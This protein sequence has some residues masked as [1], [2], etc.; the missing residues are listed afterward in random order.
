MER[1][2][3]GITGFVLCGYLLGLCF[4]GWCLNDLVWVCVGLL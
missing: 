2:F 4:L 3:Y 1:L